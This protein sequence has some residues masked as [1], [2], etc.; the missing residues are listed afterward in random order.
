MQRGQEY[1][2]LG[3]T[4]LAGVIVALAI[5]ALMAEHGRRHNPARNA[6]AYMNAEAF[7]AQF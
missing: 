7:Y 5:V 6:S 1:L 4:L 3:K 2:S